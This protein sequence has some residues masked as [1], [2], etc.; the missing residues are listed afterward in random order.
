MPYYIVR[1]W[2]TDDDWRGLADPE[3]F[4][5]RREAERTARRR[6]LRK[7]DGSRGPT[8]LSDV[9]R[10]LGGDQ[11]GRRGRGGRGRAASGLTAS[12]PAAPSTY[13]PS[14]TSCQ[15]GCSTIRTA[16]PSWPVHAPKRPRARP[17][18]RC[19]RYGQ[20]RRARRFPATLMMIARNPHR[21]LPHLR[22]DTASLGSWLH[23][24]NDWSLDSPQAVHSSLSI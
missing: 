14:T 16:Q 24:L 10:R 15:P 6:F 1:V 2:G 4:D 3:A 17:P 23:P 7:G 12:S 11:T 5:E 20:P 13:Q 18:C 8:G 9:P 22:A 21:P 19:R